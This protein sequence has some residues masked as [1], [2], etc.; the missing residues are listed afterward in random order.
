MLGVRLCYFGLQ[1]DREAKVLVLRGAVREMGSVPSHGLPKN[2]T[3]QVY[4]ASRDGR[5][6]DLE[7]FLKQLDGR[8]RKSALQPKLKMA[9]ISPLR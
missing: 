1:R 8:K 6:S 7:N 9:M 2:P 3:T 5:T 4:Q